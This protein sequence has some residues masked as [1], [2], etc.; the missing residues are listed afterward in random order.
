MDVGALIA[1]TGEIAVEKVIVM[2]RKMQKNKG[3]IVA[4][5]KQVEN[6][7]WNNSK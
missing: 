7:K 3:K 5:E 2:S 4:S 1:V 6:S